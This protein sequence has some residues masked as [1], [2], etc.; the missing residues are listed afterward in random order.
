MPMEH[1]R[2]VDLRVEP[3]PD[4]S[5]LTGLELVHILRDAITRGED[6]RRYDLSHIPETDDVDNEA[7]NP[8]CGDCL[9]LECEGFH[10]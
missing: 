8:R 5:H 6:L 7:L 3:A 10:E 2:I 4:V 1:G 9:Y